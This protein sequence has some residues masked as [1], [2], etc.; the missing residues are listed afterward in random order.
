MSIPLVY[1][2]GPF[3]APTALGREL[4]ILRAQYHGL[5]VLAAGGFPVV[6]HL[7]TGPYFGAQSESFF[8]EGTMRLMLRCDELFLT[9]GWESSAGAVKEKAYWEDARPH[10][11]ALTEDNLFSKVHNQG[12]EPPSPTNFIASAR[13]EL[14]VRIEL[15]ELR[16]SAEIYKAR[17]P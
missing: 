5:R 17:N 7:A 13:M 2:A 12:G 9:P 11:P 10:I 1:V 16:L 6:P 8:L 15:T 4:N 14:R 3:N